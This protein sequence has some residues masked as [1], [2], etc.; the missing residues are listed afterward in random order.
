MLIPRLQTRELPSWQPGKVMPG[1]LHSSKHCH[2][3]PC[4]QDDLWLI[5]RYIL[6]T[7]LYQRVSVCVCNVCCVCCSA[8]TSRENMIYSSQF[9]RGDNNEWVNIHY[10][11]PTCSSL[12]YNTCVYFLSMLFQVLLFTLFTNIITMFACPVFQS[13]PSDR[14]QALDVIGSAISCP[15]LQNWEVRDQMP[16]TRLSLA[17]AAAHPQTGEH[18]LDLYVVL[19]N[20]TLELT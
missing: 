7:R 3:E 11:V 20:I 12:L 10:L 9:I 17:I 2:T 15:A 16:K 14:R 13:P 1:A 18:H 19:H 6:E 5:E 8:S 4:P